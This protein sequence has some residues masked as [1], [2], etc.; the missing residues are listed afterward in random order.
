[1]RD[2]N[3]F[4]PYVTV[5]PKP[6]GKTLLLIG[7]LIFAVALL[8][9]YQVFLMMRTSAAKT[10]LNTLTTFIES[11]DTKAK[12]QNVINKQNKEA[13]LQASLESLKQ[14]D[15]FIEQTEIVTVDFVQAISDVAPDNLFLAEISVAE[16]ILSIKGFASAYDAVAQFANNLRQIEDVHSVLI[17]SVIEDNG[18]Y[19]YSIMT[20]LGEEVQDESK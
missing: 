4:D 11:A 6:M 5:A 9:F 15:G 17:P 18:N 14:I 10:E 12:V 20:G 3:F 8:A 19:A 13:T 2:F 7:F 16:N 1:M